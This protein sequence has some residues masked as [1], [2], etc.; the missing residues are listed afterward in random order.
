M[1]T[2]RRLRGKWLALL[3]AL[4]TAVAL[5]MLGAQRPVLQY[6]AVAPAQ[7]EPVSTQA[8]QS[9]DEVPAEDNQ[10]EQSAPSTLASLASAWE[11]AS[12]GDVNEVVSVTT[13][14]ARDYGFS[15]SSDAGTATATLLAVGAGYFEVYPR[16]LA[17]GRLPSAEEI[18][19]GARVVVLDEPLAFKLFATTDP[20]AQRLR[21]GEAWYDVIGVTRW[22]RDVGRYEQYQAYIPFACAARDVLAMETVE[23]GALPIPRSGAARV[24][25]EAASAWL[26]GGTFVD[27]QKEAMR[28]TIIA[29]AVAVVL[30]IYG[31]AWLVRAFARRVGR[32]VQ[33]VRARLQTAYLRD[34]LA[35]LLP[36]AAA[37]ALLA[38]LLVAAAYGVLAFAIQPAYVFTEWIPEVLVELSSITG[39]F[40]QLASAAARPVRVYTEE[41]ARIRFWAGFLR[42][43]VLAVLTG[44]LLMA[45]SAKSRKKQALQKTEKP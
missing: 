8:A 44:A 38:A 3:G 39:R 13:I 35:Y 17:S 11:T 41:Y 45:L 5:G 32:F 33:K 2:K 12:K 30:G 14:A 20:L 18:Q 1:E 7:G 40:W 19:S 28:A 31:L 10:P 34:M 29:R 24:F 6:A 36:R 22:S 9:G 23:I 25:E 43:G 15:L 21:I 4:L 16:Y 37:Y 42:W 27:A 26:Q